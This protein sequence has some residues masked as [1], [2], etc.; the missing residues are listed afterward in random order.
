MR[1]ELMPKVHIARI[2]GG[3]GYATSCRACGT[4]GYAL[5]VVTA[6]GFK[7]RH[8]KCREGDRR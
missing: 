6:K 2:Q 7:R 4:W 3:N 5:D 8:D 1:L